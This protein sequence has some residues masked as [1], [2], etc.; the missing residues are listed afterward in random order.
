MAD[1]KAKPGQISIASGG[2]GTMTHLL[3]EQFQAEAGLRLIHVPY[4]GGAPALNDVLAGHVPVYFDT[5]TTSASSSKKQAA[6]ARDRQPERSPAL[7]D[8]PTFAE[9]GY[10][11]VQGIDV[12]RDHGAGG[13]APEIVG[14]T[15]R[16][17]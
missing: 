6:R 10:P 3:A 15:E 5:L 13:D 7:P 2:N 14:Q 12:V 11:E 9:S 8:V 17:G 16:G 1:A 4:K